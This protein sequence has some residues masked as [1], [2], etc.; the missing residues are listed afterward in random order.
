MTQEQEHMQRVQQ[1][2][3]HLGLCT[4]S[5]CTN[6]AVDSPGWDKEYCSNGCCVAHCRYAFICNMCG[7][8]VSALWALLIW[9]RRCYSIDKN[10]LFMSSGVS[11]RACERKSAKKRASEASRGN[12]E[13]REQM[14]QYSGVEMISFLWALAALGLSMFWWCKSQQWQHVSSGMCLQ[15]GWLRG[16]RTLPE[17]NVTRR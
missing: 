6:M 4:R 11:E 12:S 5:G 14:A 15:R 10:F 8:L 7:S 17:S 1:Q 9:N 2:R 3:Q 13:R 16:K